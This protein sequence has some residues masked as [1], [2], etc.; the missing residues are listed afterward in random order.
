MKSPF[1]L[2]LLALSC[3]LLPLHAAAKPVKCVDDKGRTRYVDDA[4]VAE[5]KCKV[6]KATDNVSKA[7]PRTRTDAPGFHGEPGAP[8]PSTCVPSP[9]STYEEYCGSGKK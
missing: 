6:V 7:T 4:T 8:P 1:L 2:G 9:G 3:A 5:A